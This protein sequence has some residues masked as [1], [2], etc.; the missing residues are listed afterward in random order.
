[1]RHVACIAAF[2]GSAIAAEPAAIGS[3][4]VTPS[5]GGLT[6]SADVMGYANAPAT[7]EATLEIVRTDTNGSVRTRQVKTVE[8]TAGETSRVAQT[9]VSMAPDGTL[10]IEL[11]IRHADSV[12]H[13]VTHRVVNETTD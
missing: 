4:G 8:V 1:M 7:V 3:I 9:S 13:R 10:D 11:I 5:E 12:I 2:T 6:I